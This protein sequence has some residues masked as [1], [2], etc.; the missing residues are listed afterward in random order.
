[1]KIRKT[2]IAPDL[3]ANMPGALSEDPASIPLQRSIHQNLNTARVAYLV[4]FEADSAGAE[5][6]RFIDG[7]LQRAALGAEPEAVVDQL[8]IPG[9][10]IILPPYKRMLELVGQAA[11][12]PVACL[13]RLIWD[14]SPAMEAEH[15]KA[16]HKA[17]LKPP[18]SGSVGWF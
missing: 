16:L 9:H 6:L 4:E 2:I 15:C 18:C 17:A 12:Q 10:E 5:L 13:R 14:A 8:R 7:C 11:S 1:M 3:S